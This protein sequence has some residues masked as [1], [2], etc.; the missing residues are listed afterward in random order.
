MAESRHGYENRKFSSI[1]LA[2]VHI[3]ENI[4]SS[5]EE[6]AEIKSDTPE[7]LISQN[8][9]T[10]FANSLP[11]WNSE[12]TI[13]VSTNNLIETRPEGSRSDDNES[14]AQSNSLAEG[15]SGLI[16]SH[17]ESSLSN[18]GY[19]DN[20]LSEVDYESTQNKDISKSCS[21]LYKVLEVLGLSVVVLIL[22]GLYTIPTL[23][24]INPH[25]NFPSVSL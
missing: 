23:L 1:R 19:E 20:S 3:N 6:F 14:Q 17:D 4:G 16:S 7:V 8:S 25:L 18:V 5:S 24:F 11:V 21:H 22:F 12:D 9:F 13:C 10:I 2:V 15:R